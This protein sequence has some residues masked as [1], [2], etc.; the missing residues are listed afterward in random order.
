ML[1]Q[2]SNG[3]TDSTPIVPERFEIA[4]AEG[5]EGEEEEEEEERERDIYIYIYIYGKTYVRAYRM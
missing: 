2:S 3:L 4:I 5:E 1:L